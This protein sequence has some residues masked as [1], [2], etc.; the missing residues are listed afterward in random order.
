MQLQ[1]YG[2]RVISLTSNGAASNRKLYRMMHVD[3]DAATH[4]YVPTP[5]RMPN[6]YTT[7][8]RYIYFISDVPHLIK[9]ARNC[10]ANSYAHNFRRKLWVTFDRF[11]DCLNVSNLTEGRKSRKKDLYPY[12]TPDDDRFH[13][14]D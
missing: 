5:Y 1:L 9:T 12:R 11:F 4:D 6:P 14:S 8:D 13:V 7:E 2:F 3:S 10:W